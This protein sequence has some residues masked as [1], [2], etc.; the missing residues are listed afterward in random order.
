M[1]NIL[2]TCRNLSQYLLNPHSLSQQQVED[3]VLNAVVYGTTI[4]AIAITARTGLPVGTVSRALALGAAAGTGAV[5]EA[6]KSA[7]LALS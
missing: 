4:G 7:D 5:Q 1:T 6:S 3:M 2:Q